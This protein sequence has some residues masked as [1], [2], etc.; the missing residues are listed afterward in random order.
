MYTT[1]TWRATPMSNFTKITSNAKYP[2]HVVRKAAR[3]MLLNAAY[4][5]RGL[6]EQAVSVLMDALSKVGY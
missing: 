3:K 1:D 5:F 6:D 4:G 2:T